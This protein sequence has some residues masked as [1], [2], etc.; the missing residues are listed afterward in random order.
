MGD[1]K[2]SEYKEGTV[3]NECAKFYNFYHTVLGGFALSVLFLNKGLEINA[4][5]FFF[6]SN[7]SINRKKTD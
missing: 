5:Q 1:M 3:L 7:S 6:L 2:L 4:F